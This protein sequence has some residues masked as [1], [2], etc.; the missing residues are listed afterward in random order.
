MF[1]KDYEPIKG[2]LLAIDN[3]A[4]KGRKTTNLSLTIIITNKPRDE[5]FSQFLATA[6]ILLFSEEIFNTSSQAY[7]HFFVNVA[8]IRTHDPKLHVLNTLGVV[9]PW[10]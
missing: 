3:P 4:G 9:L 10:S 1:T 8:S 6:I 5:P 7:V 2:Y